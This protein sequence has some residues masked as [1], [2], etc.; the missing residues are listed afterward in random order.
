MIVEIDELEDVFA[1]F[2]VTAVMDDG[3]S[4]H[5]RRYR[6]Y[7]NSHGEL[8]LATSNSFKGYFSGMAYDP[9]DGQYS[10]WCTPESKSSGADLLRDLLD[11]CS[12]YGVE[13]PRE[14]ASYAY[15]LAGSIADFYNEADE[16]D[17]AVDD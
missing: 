4:T 1:D 6:V 14:L 13:I 7:E 11:F 5:K 17:D 9:D 3:K 2:T 15:C 12:D 10:E 8:M 16:D